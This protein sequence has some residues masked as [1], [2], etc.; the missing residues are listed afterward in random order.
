MV[1]VASE[2]PL[3]DGMPSAVAMRW[4][5][6]GSMRMLMKAGQPTAMKPRRATMSVPCGGVMLYSGSLKMPTVGWITRTS[7]IPT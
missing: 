3:A 1:V 2:R 5:S 7:V 4:K 6:T